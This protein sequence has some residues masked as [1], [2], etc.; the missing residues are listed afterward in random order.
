MPRPKKEKLER[1]ETSIR[2]RISMEQK[3]LLL[4]AAALEGLELSS[5]MRS[6]ALRAAAASGIK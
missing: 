1:K 6:I 2:I 3:R 5:W 4:R